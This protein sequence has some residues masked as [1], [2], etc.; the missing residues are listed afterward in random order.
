MTT[1]NLDI[2][3]ET[4]PPSDSIN[5]LSKTRY[6]VKAS[7]TDDSPTMASVEVG[8][9]THET[10]DE[11]PENINGEV[12]GPEAKPKKT[13][14]AK[15]IDEITAEKYQAIEALHRAQKEL[16]D[17]K[18]Q[19]SNKGARDEQE[20]VQEI[21]FTKTPA[22]FDDYESY[23]IAIAEHRIEQKFNARRIEEKS[24]QVAEEK[25]K[26][27]NSFLTKV[28]E[29][30]KTANDYSSVVNDKVPIN[31]SMRDVIFAS[32]NGPAIAYYLGKNLDEAN[33]IWEL[34]PHIAAYELG[35]IESKITAQ[36]S[37]KPT[38]APAPIADIGSREKV[39]KSI[40]DMSNE[41]YRRLRMK[42]V[43]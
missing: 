38:N 42:G 37:K 29:F 24:K 7:S 40:D 39:T 27:V 4:A 3:S 28:G 15:R 22:D 13:G 26:L 9:E 10:N 41:E 12:D 14:I 11:S 32:D 36:K 19:S 18:A 31:E 6:V 2:N 30:S 23:L 5:D 33:K 1:E 34:P 35:K 17:Y 8:E 16:E 21:P 20:S 25:T 43:I